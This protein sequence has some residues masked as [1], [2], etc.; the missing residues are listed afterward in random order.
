MLEN[1]RTR[2]SDASGL[3]ALG[4]EMH[5]TSQGLNGYFIM[6]I[7]FLLLNFLGKVPLTF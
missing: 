2:G 3:P 4:C 1:P 5:P 7:H 6:E